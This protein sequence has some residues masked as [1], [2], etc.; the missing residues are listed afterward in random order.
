M[1]EGRKQTGPV[2]Q[3]L[4]TCQRA[5]DPSLRVRKKKEMMQFQISQRGEG[6]GSRD[7]GWWR[8]VYMKE[9]FSLSVSNLTTE[10]DASLFPGRDDE[11]KH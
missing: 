3:A 9:N 11:E 7:G 6:R 5:N 10:N 4:Q 8:V 2:I 1:F